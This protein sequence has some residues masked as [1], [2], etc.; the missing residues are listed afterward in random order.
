LSFAVIDSPSV[1]VNDLDVE[2]VTRAPTEAHSPL[3]VDAN[4]VLSRSV[5]TELLEAVARWYAEI[6]QALCCIQDEQL[7]SGDLLD[8]LSEPPSSLP[9]EQALCVPVSEASDHLR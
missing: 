9:V 7:S 8:I 1:V 5:A 4:A 2:G 3:I 6:I